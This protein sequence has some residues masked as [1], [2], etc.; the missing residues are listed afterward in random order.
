MLLN[1]LLNEYLLE[2]SIRNCSKHTIKS[3]RNNLKRFISYLGNIEL[4]KTTSTHIKQYIAH[5]Q[6]LGR[7]GTYINTILKQ[8]RGLFTYA[9]EEEYISINIVS[10]IK[11]VKE[12]TP[13]IKTFTEEELK[14]MLNYYKG[15]DYLSIR[16]KLI[17]YLLA[18]LGIRANEAINITLEDIKGNSILIHGKGGKDRVLFISQ[19]LEKLLM[20]YLRVRKAHIKDKDTNYLLVSIRRHKLTVETIEEICRELTPLARKEI[21]VSPHTFRHTYAQLCLKNGLDVYVISRLLGHTSINMTRRYLNSLPHEEIAKMAIS[22]ISF[23][24]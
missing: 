16:N 17:I 10:K 6:S 11:W 15:K 21:R 22:P 14:K 1:E 19:P 8:L 4:E 3:Y 7:K 18:D 12:I 23:I 20:K 13:V 9:Y 24:K 2:L 5:L